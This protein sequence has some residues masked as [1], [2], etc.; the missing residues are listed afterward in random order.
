DL[1][2]PHN[3]VRHHL[4]NK[5][6]GKAKSWA[7]SEEANLLFSEPGSVSGVWDNYLQPTDKKALDEKLSKA[8]I[9]L[10][11]STSIS[12]ARD[13]AYRKD[14]K[15]RRISMF[16]NP[17]GN[18]LVILAEDAKRKYTL[19]VLEFQYYRSLM[20]VDV[21]KRHLR[22]VPSMRY[23][24]SCRDITSRIPQDYVAL[25]AAIG[26]AQLKRLAVSDEAEI[27][28]WHIGTNMGVE[29]VDVGVAHFKTIQKE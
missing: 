25:H 22:N 6:V 20:N 12:V 17:A 16:L 10:D 3:T 5:Y 27:K 1:L 8:E 7:M 14:L 24:T 26:A 4:S 28:I 18:D 9:I 13:L 11:V 29:P 2:L 21:L 19:D 23:S 15:G